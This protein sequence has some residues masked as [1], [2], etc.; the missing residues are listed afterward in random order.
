MVGG[1]C[2][3]I[4]LPDRLWGMICVLNARRRV[5]TSDDLL[6][7]ESV[8][9]VIG[10][11]HRAGR[12]GADDPPPGDAR[13]PHRH[14]EPR[15]AA[16]PPARWRW[17]GP[18]GDGTLVGVLYIDL[19]RF[20]DV[21]DSYGHSTGDALLVAAAERL[22]AALRPGDTVARVG[23]DEFASIAEALSGPE[24][25][26]AL[27]ER[28]LRALADPRALHAGRQHRHRA[29]A[30]AA[31]PPRTPCATPTRRCT[32]PRPRVAAGPSCSTTRCA[33]AL[34][35]RLQTEADLRGALE[36]REF[37]LH[38]QPIVALADGSVVGGRGR[39]SAGSTRPAGWCRPAAFIAI[40]EETGAIVELGRFVIARACADAARWNATGPRLADLGERQPVGA[41]SWP[42]RAC[43]I[44]R[45]EPRRLGHPGRSARA[46]DHRDGRVRATTRSTSRACCEIKRLGVRL[47]LDDF[48]TGYSSLGHLRRFPLDVLKLDRSFVAGMGRDETDTAIVVATRQLARA[49]GLVVVAEGVET[50][51]QLASLQAIGCEYAQG[52]YFAR[53]LTRAKVDRML[54]ADPPWR[55][56][57]RRGALESD[58]V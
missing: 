30:A 44:R 50:R 35:D 20:K 48:G 53:P 14:P 40:A 25:A 5:F 31:T 43:P 56:D 22:T 15:A 18:N 23:G 39:W 10:G 33:R 11:A 37:D 24:E 45:D 9:N 6:F 51:E 12:V 58:A 34:L 13:R 52:Y 17:S 28:L 21:N 3:V 47:L 46:R 54:T 42:M 19:D 16:R 55:I 1:A 29:C 8:A 49:L 32:A 36:R 2:F 38:Y 4:R 7:L 27:A 57:E 26:L 41:A